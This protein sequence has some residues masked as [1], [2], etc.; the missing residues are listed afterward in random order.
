MPAWNFGTNSWV[1]PAYY[2]APLG[3]WAQ[4]VRQTI[5]AQQSAVF[6]WWSTEWAT[7]LGIPA[8]TVLP[9]NQIHVGVPADPNNR[10]L[11]I[12]PTGERFEGDNAEI[13]TIQLTIVYLTGPTRYSTSSAYS[14]LVVGSAYL[15][16]IASLLQVVP[17]SYLLS[18][19]PNNRPKPLIRKLLRVED[20]DSALVR[21]LQP[22]LGVQVGLTV[23]ITA[24]NQFLR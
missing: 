16:A 18:N 13:Q 20:P 1:Q 10:A 22:Q 7:A 3:Y 12:V 21:N 23:E 9:E 19:W 4:R 15:A 8:L 11:V 24:I 17:E 6:S 2:S 5:I 14:D